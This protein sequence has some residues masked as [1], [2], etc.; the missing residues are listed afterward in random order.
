MD[1][2]DILEAEQRDVVTDY[3]GREG[4]SQFYVSSQRC[5]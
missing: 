4:N 1:S 2:R 5:C 3:V